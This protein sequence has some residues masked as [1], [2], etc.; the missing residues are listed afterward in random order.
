MPTAAGRCERQT[1]HPQVGAL[2]RLL[3]PQPVR[4]AEVLHGGVSLADLLDGM[5][6]EVDAAIEGRANAADAT[7]PLGLGRQPVRHLPEVGQDHHRE[8]FPVFPRSGG[9]GQLIGPMQETLR[10][11]FCS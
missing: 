11:R 1:L 10:E 3:I 4:K 5:D 6:G 8:R 7:D 9:I 2:H